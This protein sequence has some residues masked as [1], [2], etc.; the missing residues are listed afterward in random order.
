MCTVYSEGTVYIQSN[1]LEVE[2]RKLKNREH[3][4]LFSLFI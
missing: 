3:K 2:L 1:V 4:R